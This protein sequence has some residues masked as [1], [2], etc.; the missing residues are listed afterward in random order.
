[1]SYCLS[2]CSFACLT[3]CLVCLDGP[4]C[5]LVH[6]L[7]HLIVYTRV[8]MLAS[9]ATFMYLVIQIYFSYITM[10]YQTLCLFLPIKSV[11]FILTGLYHFW[12]LLIIN[13][14]A[15]SFKFIFIIFQPYLCSSKLHCF[16]GQKSSICTLNWIVQI[17]KTA[18]ISHSISPLQLANALHHFP[19]TAIQNNLC[20]H[21]TIL[22]S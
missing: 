20:L 17:L 4:Q 13:I 2:Y 19:M 11:N 7:C 12:G 15:I 21:S 16:H 5:W 1:M 22:S 8:F 10:I 9:M 3:T 14:F 6:L 18:I